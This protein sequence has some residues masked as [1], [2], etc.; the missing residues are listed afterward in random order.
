MTLG[1]DS[2]NDYDFNLDDY[3]L[4]VR[5]LDADGTVLISKTLLTRIA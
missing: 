3:S 4:V 1:D 5:K 2:D